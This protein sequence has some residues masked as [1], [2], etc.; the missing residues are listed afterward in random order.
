MI[1]DE[2]NCSGD[3]MEAMDTFKVIIK[4]YGAFGEYAKTKTDEAVLPQD[5][6]AADL[7]NKLAGVYGGSFRDE[8]FDGAGELLDDVMVTVNESIINH[9]SVSTI[10]LKPDDEIAL[11]P[12]FRGG[13]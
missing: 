3:S 12:V 4:L 10:Y 6:T 2:L 11:L 13:G 5:A 7:L 9:G 8:L 1:N